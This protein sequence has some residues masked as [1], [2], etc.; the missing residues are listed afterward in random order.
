MKGRR[1]ITLPALSPKE[2]ARANTKEDAHQFLKSKGSVVDTSDDP[3]SDKFR[4]AIFFRIALYHVFYPL[5]VPLVLLIDGLPLT[6]NM[7]FLDMNM[8]GF[9]SNVPSMM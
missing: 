8:S 9:F 6:R 2:G 4:F 7:G 5:S 3:E 1:P